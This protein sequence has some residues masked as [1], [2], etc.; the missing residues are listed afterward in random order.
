[1]IRMKLS[2]GGQVVVPVE[3]RNI[4]GLKDGD[5]VLWELVDGEARLTTRKARLERARK[6]FQQY[7]PKQEGRSVVDEL[8]AERRAEAEREVG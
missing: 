6:L 3:I 4:L 5:A 8:I 2:E 1:M 7:F